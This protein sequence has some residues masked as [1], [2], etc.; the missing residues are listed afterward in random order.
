MAEKH[1]FI[2]RQQE[3]QYKRVEACSEEEA[4]RIATDD[5][6]W[7]DYDDHYD[8]VWAECADDCFEVVLFDPHGDP[9]LKSRYHEGAHIAD[10]LGED[11]RDAVEQ[12]QIKRV[13]K[14][15]K[16]KTNE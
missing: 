16:G 6:D 9:I 11:L 1:T 8:K 13:E 14:Y 4:I 5:G 2:V 7:D 10:D 3:V 15:E 12:Y